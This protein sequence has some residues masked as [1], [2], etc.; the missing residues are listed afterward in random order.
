MKRITFIKLA[1][2][3]VALSLTGPLQAQTYP[4]KPVKF[5]VPFSPGGLPDTVARLL[6]AN[7]QA[8]TGQ[9]F[10]IDNKAG[11]NGSIA[12]AALV[13]APADGYTFLISDGASLAIAPV[14]LTKLPYDPEK[15]FAPVSLIGTAPLFLAVNANVKAN[16]LD[17]LIALAKAKPGTLNYGSAG[18]GSIHHLTAEAMK[19]GFGVDVA[20][21]PFKGSGVS[22]PAMIGAQVDM[23]FASPPS[24]MGFVKSGQAKLLA[25][26]SAKRS[27]LAPDVPT[28]GEKL[29]GFDFAFTLPVIAR[30]GT[31]REAIDKIS[32]EIARIVRQPDVA[33]QLQMAGVDPIG[34]TPE[35][36][37]KALQEEAKRI[38]AAARHANLKPQ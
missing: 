38:T 5:I 18:N 22:V 15:D 1:T 6:G 12:A 37:S 23:V 14:L 32:S 31:P 8:A 36:L 20:H 26:N 3:A 9:P 7:L 30:A 10:V 28:L 17:E 29:P 2:L 19:A 35:Q 16:T 27:P 24:L 25:V 21:I 11:A 33:Q 13:Q 34:G 4:S